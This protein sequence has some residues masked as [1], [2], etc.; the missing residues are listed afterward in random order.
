L[1]KRQGRNYRELAATAG[2]NLPINAFTDDFSAWLDLFTRKIK[3]KRI[4]K[5]SNGKRLSTIT[6]S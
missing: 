2:R 4:G 5:A 6:I 3:T 1:E